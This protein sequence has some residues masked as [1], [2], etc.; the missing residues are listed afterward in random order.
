MGE[1]SAYFNFNV[2]AALYEATLNLA[3]DFLVRLGLLGGGGDGGST[4][5]LESWR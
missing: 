5:R 1:G 2:N 4:T 3:D